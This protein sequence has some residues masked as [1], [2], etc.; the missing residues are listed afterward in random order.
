MK[1]SNRLGQCLTYSPVNTLHVPRGTHDSVPDR[2]CTRSLKSPSSLEL[3]FSPMFKIAGAILLPFVCLYILQTVD[4]IH[5]LPILSTEM[6][7]NSTFIYK[8]IIYTKI[9]HTLNQPPAA[10]ILEVFSVTSSP[11][12]AYSIEE[13]YLL[14][15][16]IL[17]FGK[18]LS[19][20][21]M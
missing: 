21:I 18:L 6:A 20:L 17:G 12:S 1:K 2:K 4:S 7:S 19:L 3:M 13:V 9:T 14:F 15:F 8:K 10:A 11:V 16:S 5:S